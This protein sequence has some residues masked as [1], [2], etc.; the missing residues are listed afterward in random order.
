MADSVEIDFIGVETSK[1]GDAITVRYTINGTTQIHVVDGGYIDT[2]PQIIEHL[3]QHY[4]TTRIDHVVLTHPDRDHANGLRA[5]LENCSVG[6]LWLNRPWQ[7]A[8][9]LLPR[10]AT[11]TSADALERKL[12]SV[13]S[14]SATLE[15]I[16]L[17]RNIPI[18]SPLQGQRIGAFHV[19]APS[20]RRYL[21]LIV[22]S[23]KTPEA[24]EASVIGESF[25][26]IAKAFRALTN[27]VKSVWGNEYF[28]AAGTS[29][30]NEMSVVQ[31]AKINESK[32]LLTGD[33][34]R[35][36]LTE[37]ADFAPHVGLALPGLE[38]FQVPHH[39]GR[40]NVSTEV[41][42]RWLGERLPSLPDEPVWSAICS[43]AKA[44][45]DHPRKSVVRAMMHRGAH[46]AATEGTDILWF[47][48]NQRVGWSA[49]PQTAYP[50]EQEN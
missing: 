12:R 32:I 40:H 27:L 23:E 15:A 20:R 26:G 46:F 19:L 9:E 35:E 11:Y 18:Y 24:E 39:G 38:L 37:A 48:G 25:E 14:A 5:V 2:G 3:Q 16:A 36:G 30:E 45:E 1:S 33:T 42:D 50:E 49:V 28:P 8:A 29:S 17:A 43:S 21:D 10:F 47:N 44:D 41:L 4:G 7:Y 34:G 22:E 6:A 13:Y 31:Y